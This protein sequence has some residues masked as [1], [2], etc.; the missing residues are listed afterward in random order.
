MVASVERLARRSDVY[1]IAVDEAGEFFANGILVH[2]CDE[3]AAWRYPESWDQA[4]FGLR[5]GNDPRAVLTTT[6]KPTKVVKEIVADPNTVVTVGSTYE[7]RANLA[8]AFVSAIVRKYEGTRLGRQELE[9]EILSDNPGAL[10][11][12]DWIESSR[13]PKAPELRR[14][15]VAVDPAATSNPD[16]DET[17]IIVAGLGRDGLGYILADVSMRGTPE[18]WGRV[19]TRAY[20]EWKADRIVA[21]TNN[22][23]QMIEAVVRSID[24]GVSYRGVHASRGKVTRAEPVSALY[25]QGRIK[26]VGSFPTLEDQM[27]DYDPATSRE[28]PDRMD[29]LVWAVTELLIDGPGQATVTP[30]RV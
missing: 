12:R 10:W 8:D 20:R 3:L 18:Q 26:H 19:V 1:D 29:A 22:G 17:G 2:N 15:V 28:S 23:G 6:P 16:S 7:N 13:V 21:E 25:E 24:R 5:L 30:L 27:C 14:I 9:A 11:K 4:K